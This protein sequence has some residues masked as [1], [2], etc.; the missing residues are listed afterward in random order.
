MFHVERGQP[1][2]L[3]VSKASCRKEYGLPALVDFCIGQLEKGS[4]RVMLR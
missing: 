2:V 3:V 4:E 1:E